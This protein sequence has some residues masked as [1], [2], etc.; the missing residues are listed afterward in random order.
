MQLWSSHSPIERLA[1]RLVAGSESARVV[2]LVLWAMLDE[3]PEH[4]AARVEKAGRN[5]EGRILAV[6]A[7]G[8]ALPQNVQP[9]AFPRKLFE[10]L[11]PTVNARNRVAY[12]GRASAKSWS[13]AIALILESLVRPIRALCAR[14]FQ[15]S[16]DESVYKLLVTVIERFALDRWFTIY[17]D[18]ITSHCGAEFSFVG[19]KHNASKVRS[20]EGITHCWCEEAT[21][22]SEDSWRI[23]TPTVRLP[24]S[25]FY[26]SFNPDQQS[27]P[28]YQRF[29]VTPPPQTLSAFVNADE[30]PWLTDE[31]RAERD[32][33]RRVDAD[34]AAWIWGGQIRTIS[35]AIVFAGKYVIDSFTPAE[36]WDGPY[37]GLDLGFGD[38]T[39]LTKC[40]VFD[41]KLFVEAEAW[42]LRCDIDKLPALLDQIPGSRKHTIR[43][44][45]SRPET[46]SYL[47]QHGYPDVVSVEKWP[48]SVADGVSRMRGFEQIVLHSSCEHTAQEFRL[49]SYKTDR[50]THDVLPDIVDKHNHCIDSIRYGIAPLIRRPAGAG[51]IEYYQNELAKMKQ[52]ADISQPSSPQ[53]Q[54]PAN[55]HAGLP[56]ESLIA[57]ARRLGGSWSP[58]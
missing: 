58:L 32:Y 47:K 7:H 21:Y 53:P 56:G 12:G 23:L 22:I 14:E 44:D 2:P 55:P 48:D 11:H 33:L 41:G 38:P 36:G 3:T 5:W 26:I 31:M 40:W 24:G 35:N 45:S 30:N 18:S 39:V 29:V 25:Q 17:R 50:L 27:D 19:L 28:T 49:Y 20:Y 43:V 46:V 42:Q 57:R 10:L 51:I 37:F 16:I 8:F 34:A 54:Q 1:R 52:G 9:V 4:F 6:C 13:F 15:N